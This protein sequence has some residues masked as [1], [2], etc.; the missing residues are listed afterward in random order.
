MHEIRKDTQDQQVKP[1]S[2]NPFISNPMSLPILPTQPSTIMSQ[3]ASGLTRHE[4]IFV[5]HDQPLLQVAET[6]DSGRGQHIYDN[7]PAETGGSNASSEASTRTLYHRSEIPATAESPSQ[8]PPKAP[9]AFLKPM[10][11]PVR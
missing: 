6:L 10:G 7:P 3:E 9:R 1:Q 8:P 4:T 5:V 2:T 11:I